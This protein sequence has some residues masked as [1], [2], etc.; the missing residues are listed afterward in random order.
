M[1][2]PFAPEPDYD[3]LRHDET[4]MGAASIIKTHLPLDAVVFLLLV[5]GVL[6]AAAIYGFFKL[7]RTRLFPSKQKQRIQVFCL[8]G[9][10]LFFSYA[11]WK[12]MGLYHA[13]FPSPIIH[14]KD[15]ALGLGTLLL[16]AAA[17]YPISK[18]MCMREP[19]R[20]Y[21]SLPQS[22]PEMGVWAA[23]SISAGVFEEI[24][25]R[26]VLFSILMIL[27][28][29]WW[30]ATLICAACFG[31]AHFE[32][33]ENIIATF[34][35]AILLQ[36]VVYFTGYLYVAMFIHAAYDFIV[37][38]FCVHFWKQFASARAVETPAPASIE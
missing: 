17:I 33:S 24:A 35:I 18:R 15:A 6:P 9:F 22:L 13:L 10:L 23:V 28:H 32:G 11:V 2:I 37:G 36:A 7:K 5:G 34:V 25:Y 21:R 4:R 19:A 38:L 14:L 27:V 16:L 12:A 31:L 1:H 20:V 29:S 26:G 8:H 3:F 30:P